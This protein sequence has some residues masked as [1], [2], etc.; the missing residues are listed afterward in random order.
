M[1]YDL[2]MRQ[3]ARGMT[4]AHGDLREV[5]FYD[6]SNYISILCF[7]DGT[8][9]PTRYYD[10]GDKFFQT[11]A[12][13]VNHY[14]YM[15]AAGSQI[16]DQDPLSLLTFGYG[17]TGSRCYSVFLESCGFT[18]TAVDGIT[19]PYRLRRDGTGAGG[20]GSKDVIQWEDGTQTPRPRIRMK[21]FLRKKFVPA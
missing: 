3:F 8:N 15:D 5:V 10:K 9:L 6:A 1:E 11:I 14:P 20:Q 19:A 21:A 17:G 12:Y 2:L 7:K 13:S 4:S 18:R 16:G